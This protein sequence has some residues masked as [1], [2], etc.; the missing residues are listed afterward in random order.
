MTNLNIWDITNGQPEVSNVIKK[1]GKIC[2]IAG[3]IMKLQAAVFVNICLCCICVSAFAADLGK[4]VQ[5]ERLAKYSFIRTE[6]DAGA[7]GLLI[8]NA[9]LGGLAD[10]SGLSIPKIWGSVERA[11]GLTLDY[12]DETGTPHRESF[13]GFLATIIQHETDHTNGVLFVQRILEQKGKLYQSATD[14]NGK[15]ILE[16][17]ELT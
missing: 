5:Q 11:A 7:I 2:N 6:Y 13:T 15:E 9:E 8:G 17:V 1:G 3:N 14:E 4:A 10:G 12:Q 16:E